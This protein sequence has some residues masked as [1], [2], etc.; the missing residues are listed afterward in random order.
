[1]DE[2]GRASKDDVQ[3]ILAAMIKPVRYLHRNNIIHRD[4]KPENFIF[5]ARDFSLKLIDFGSVEFGSLN[6][7]LI[8]TS[9]RDPVGDIGYIAPEYLVKGVGSTQSDLF[10]IASIVYE[11]ITADLPYSAIL[12]QQDY[13]RQYDVWRYRSIFA[14]RK[15]LNGHYP[16]WLDSVMRKALCPRPE[17]R[18]EVLSEFE[19]EFTSPS[20]EIKRYARAVP[21]IDRNPIRFYQVVTLILVSVIAVQAIV[22]ASLS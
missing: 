7:D 17:E 1:M 5:D 8:T 18:F 10:S 14:S 19:K 4:L 20:A 9:G 15:P 3:K 21:L 2:Q 12:S 6:D 11:L 22:I 13:P 16:L